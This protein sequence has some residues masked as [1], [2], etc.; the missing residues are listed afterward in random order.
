MAVIEGAEGVVSRP[1]TEL[2]IEVAKLQVFY[3]LAEKMSRFIIVC[4]LFIKM[5]IRK[6]IVEEQI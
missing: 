2:S 4:R 6:D 5:R 3:R 1:N